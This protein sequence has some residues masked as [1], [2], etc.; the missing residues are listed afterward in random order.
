MAKR[1]FTWDTWDFDCNGTAYII[2][3]DECPNIEDVP[4]YGDYGIK[5][6]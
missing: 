5:E 2:A 1:Y 6:G 3:L 4:K